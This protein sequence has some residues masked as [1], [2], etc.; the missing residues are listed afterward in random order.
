MKVMFFMAIQTI[1]FLY[2]AS[3]QFENVLI[4][5]INIINTKDLIRLFINLNETYKVE[6]E[7][8][9]KN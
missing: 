6:S 9:N 1:F 2:V 3:K 7:K 5:K 8:I 4:D